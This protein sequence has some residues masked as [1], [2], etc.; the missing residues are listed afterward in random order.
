M[1]GQKPMNA[2]KAAALI[3]LGMSFNHLLLKLTSVETVEY[4]LLWIVFVLA[5]LVST[6]DCRR[7]TKSEGSE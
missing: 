5:T 7:N 4:W 1:I 2:I 6:T 3:V